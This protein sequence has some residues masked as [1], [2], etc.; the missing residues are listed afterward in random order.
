[1]NNTTPSTPD[2]IVHPTEEGKDVFSR[3]QKLS[4]N[5]CK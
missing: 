3:Q 5:S 1:M 4:K 2:D